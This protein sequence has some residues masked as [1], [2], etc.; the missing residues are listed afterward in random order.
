[1][2]G[3]VGYVGP[4]PALD[5]VVE[6]LRRLEYRGYDSAGRRGDRRRAAAAG[7]Q[8]GRPDREPG[9]GTGHP[10]DR[11]A[12]PAWDTPAGRRTAH[13]TTATP[14]RTPDV[15]GR[16]AVVH[17]GIIENFAELR[18]ELE[19]RRRRD[20]QRDRHR[21]RGAP[22]RR[23]GAAPA[24]ALAD[25]V[26]AVCRRLH[27]AFTLVLLDAEEPDVV[28]AA[29]RNSPLVVGVGEGE[30]FLGSDVAAFIEFTREAVELGQD[31]IVETAPRRLH[32]HRLRR[33]SRPRARPFHIDWDLAAAEK[34]GFDY[35]MLKEIE[36]QPAAV[37]DT[38]LGH[39][40]DGQIVLDE[41]RLDRQEL[42][43]IDKVFVVACGIG[44]PRRADRQAGHRALDAHAGRGRDGLGVP[45]PRPGARPADA[46]RRD[47]PV[48]R[49]GG[50]AG[51]GAARPRAARPGAGD[52]QHQRR[53][54]PARVRRGA[55]HPR[56]ARDRGRGDED[57]RRPRSPRPSWSG[58][59]W[60]RPAAPSTATRSRASTTALAA[61]PQQITRT[62]GAGRRGPGARARHRRRE[63]GPVPRPARRLPGR[64]R[65]CAQA[66]GTGLHAR[67]GVP[68]RRAQARADRAH[69]G[70]PAGRRRHAVADRPAGAAPEDAEQ[71]RRGA[72][73]RARGRS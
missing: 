18:D 7:G 68:G 64:A 70:R 14:T 13:R 72:G 20:G 23:A 46:R 69:R 44:L 4:R 30:M 63:G 49:D 56:R 66:Q 5:V 33:R 37:A 16:I 65:G 71:H 34:G 12:T 67:R 32:D 2:C 28:V 50:H 25:A 40:V 57:V 9:Q 45:L 52:L 62:L 35:F 15:D 11:R 58:S 39:F 61:I 31:Q 38:L 29:R 55:L 1:M 22:G 43:D 48:R 53:A 42:R 47:Q 60:P 8:E 59:R 73:A 41:Q 10:G 54:D 26:R 27:G 3:I 6:G 17:N 21:G 24:A 19:P 51:G 36:E